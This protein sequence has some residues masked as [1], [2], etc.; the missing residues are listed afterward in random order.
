MK[1]NPVST[2]LDDE[3]TTVSVTLT[4]IGESSGS[5]DVNLTVDGTVQKKQKLSD[6]S[7][8]AS[9]LNVEFEITETAGGTHT[10]EIDNLSGTFVVEKFRFCLCGS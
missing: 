7:G 2:V 4:N 8:A 9:M 1:I 6:L 5:Y 3:P 10:V